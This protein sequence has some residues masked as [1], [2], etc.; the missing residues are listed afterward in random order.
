MSLDGYIADADGGYDW[1]VHDPT[2][3]FG[4]IFS[5]FDTL[6]MGRKTF[7]LTRKQGGGMTGRMRTVVVSRTLAQPDFPKVEIVNE[8]P[9]AAVG[10]LKREAGKDIW[11]FGGGELFRTLFDAGV[12]DGIDVAVIPVMLGGGIPFIAPGKPSKP[13]RL[14]DTKAYPSGIV[15]LTYAVTA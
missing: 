11:L 13:L 14:T 2:I 12:V 7:D 15:G 4:A 1:I 6:V 10:A 5:Q 8:N 3:D 9:G